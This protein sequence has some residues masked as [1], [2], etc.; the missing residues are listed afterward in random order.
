MGEGAAENV[1]EDP[2][3][4]YVTQALHGEEGRYCSNVT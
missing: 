1:N 4:V 2:S 3:V